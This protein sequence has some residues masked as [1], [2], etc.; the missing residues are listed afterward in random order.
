MRFEVAFGRWSHISN[1]V[2]HHGL[3][4]AIHVI[5]SANVRFSNNVIF[6]FKRFGINVQSSSNATVTGNLVG[7][8]R[9]RGYK[10]LD[11]MIEISAGIL[12]CALDG[13]TSCPGLSIT[14]NIVAGLDT[15]AYSVPG[16]ACG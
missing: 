15:T 4:I 9:N 10:T 3:G 11:R 13:G 6:D 7:N 5:A 14:H 1:S 16:H 12:G 8:I 2:I